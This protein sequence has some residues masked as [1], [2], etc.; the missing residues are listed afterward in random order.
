LTATARILV[1]EDEPDMLTILRDNLELEGYRVDLATTGEEG[2][3]LALRDSPDVVLLDIMLPGM[4][5]YDVCRN[6]R[7]RGVRT[8]I[9]LITARNSEMD[10]VAGLDLGADDYVGKPFNI[11]EVLARV[12][13][14]IRHGRDQ[15]PQRRDEFRFGNVVVDV[16]RQIVKRAGKRVEMTSREFQLLSYFILHQGELVT[17]DQLLIDVWGYSHPPLTRA[18]DNFVFKL[19]SKLEADPQH[20]RYFLTAY[21]TGYRFTV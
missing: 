17:R 10:R 8:P 6:L 14:Q 11:G 1:V 7:S 9:I 16:R 20:P 18:V 3:K 4:S 13:V 15:E 19:R 21:G 2:L 12:R 5:G